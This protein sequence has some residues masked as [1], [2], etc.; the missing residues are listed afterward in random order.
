MSYSLAKAPAVTTVNASAEIRHRLVSCRKEIVVIESER[1]EERKK[2]KEKGKGKEGAKEEERKRSEIG[3]SAEETRTVS[4]RT[5]GERVG[6][7]AASAR[8]RVKRVNA[9]LRVCCW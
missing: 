2:E 5:Q 1:G 7:Y 8:A 6:E 9:P 3:C 4:K